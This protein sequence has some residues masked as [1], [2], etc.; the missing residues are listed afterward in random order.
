MQVNLRNT[1][2]VNARQIF[3]ECAKACGL[4]WSV[5]NVDHTYTFEMLHPACRLVVPYDK[6][7]LYHIGTR[8]RRNGWREIDSD[9]KVPKPET[10]PML[11]TMEQCCAYVNR[12]HFTKGE[13]LVVCDKSEYYNG[14]SWRRIKIKGRSYT[15]EHVHLE[16]TPTNA[17]RVTNNYMLDRWLAGEEDIVRTYHPELKQR[18]EE[19]LT[20]IGHIEQ[21][22]QVHQS[23]YPTK[24]DYFSNI[25]NPVVNKKW[26]SILKAM[27]DKPIAQLRTLGKPMISQAL[28]LG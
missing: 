25:T 21:A 3:D 5:L 7:Q 17:K 12:L 23:T 28:Q 2:G 1:D 18:F 20:Q 24:P 26:A 10:M 8:D 13:G 15:C 16:L 19:M 22:V 6:P 4:D 14:R 27:F 9:I 11:R